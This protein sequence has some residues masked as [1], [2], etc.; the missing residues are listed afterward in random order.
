[1]DARTESKHPAASCGPDPATDVGRSLDG[2]GSRTISAPTKTESPPS[3]NNFIEEAFVDR[4]SLSAAI[5]ESEPPPMAA[6][7]TLTPSALEHLVRGCLAKA[8]DD[9]SPDG[10]W[11][12]Y[13]SDESGKYQIYVQSYPTLGNKKPVSADV[14]LYPKWRRDG[15]ELYFLTY[16][17]LEPTLMVSTVTSTGSTIAFS[18]P[19]PLF[20]APLTSDNWIN[21]QYS[22]SPTGDRFLFNALVESA[23]PPA[24]NVVLNWKRP[25][26]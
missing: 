2:S 9:P 15:R 12:A 5:L 24:I 17:G 6:L 8:P 13:M 16:R 21:D 19:R 20:S 3:S 23:A 1:V 10:R 14:G 22:P 25:S 18:L 7:Q 26:Q 4:L 11:M